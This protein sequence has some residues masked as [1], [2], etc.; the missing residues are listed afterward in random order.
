MN[1]THQASVS[2]TSTLKLK[3]I[4]LGQ[5][6]REG[7]FPSAPVMKTPFGQSADKQPYGQEWSFSEQIASLMPAIYSCV[8]DRT[9]SS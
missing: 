4:N 8:T 1:D 5:K 7:M 9:L 2:A 6:G 3:E